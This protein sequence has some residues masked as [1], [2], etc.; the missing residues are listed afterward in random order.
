MKIKL[1]KEQRAFIEQALTSVLDTV[2]VYVADM[3]AKKYGENDWALTYKQVLNTEQQHNWEKED[4]KGTKTEN[5]IDFGHL[6][7][8]A[9]KFKDLWKADFDAEV[10]SLPTRFDQICKFRNQFYHHVDTISSDDFNS[11]WINARAIAKGMGQAALVEELHELEEKTLKATYNADLEPNLVGSVPETPAPS[12]PEANPEEKVEDDVE[13]DIQRDDYAVPVPSATYFLPILVRG[14][15]AHTVHLCKGECN[16]YIRSFIFEKGGD[17]ILLFSLIRGALQGKTTANRNLL[18][19]IVE[20]KEDNDTLVVVLEQVDELTENSITTPEGV[21]VQYLSNKK[22]QQLHALHHKNYTKVVWQLQMQ[23][24][25]YTGEINCAFA[26]R[27]KI[28]DIALDFGSEASQ[29]INQN[30][31]LKYLNRSKILESFKV[32]YYPSLK[33]DY[34]QQDADPELYRSQLF[35]KKEGSVMEIKGCPNQYKGLDVI[36]MLTAI[37]KS[38]DLKRDYLL[39]PNP[40]LA[41]LGVYSFDLVFKDAKKSNPYKRAKINSGEVMADLRQ[42]AINHILHA[43]LGNIQVPEDTDEKVYVHVKLLVPNILEQE[44][45]T[46]LIKRTYEFL[47]H[48]S[49]RNMYSIGGVEVSIISES[50]ASFLGYWKKP[51]TGIQVADANYLIIDVGKGTTDFSIIQSDKS[52]NLS[53]AFRSGFVGAGGMITY[54]FIETIVKALLG[55]DTANKKEMAKLLNIIASEQTDI[56]AKFNFLE[57]IEKIKRKYIDN[58]ESVQPLED[59]IDA[60]TIS[61]FRKRVQENISVSGMLADI[62][63]A[64]E[65]NVLPKQESIGDDFGLIN[66]SV[67][68]WVESLEKQVT[69]SGVEGLM[70]SFNDFDKLIL[71]GRGFMFDMLRIELEGKLGK[72]NSHKIVFRSKE[73]EPKKICLDGVFSDHS[74]NYDASLVGL[75]YVYQLVKTEHSVQLYIDKGMGDVP[76]K[77]DVTDKEDMLDEAFRNANTVLNWKNKVANFFKDD[78]EEEVAKKQPEP[79]PVVEELPK[80]EEELPPILKFISKGARFNIENESE[81]TKRVLISN[82]EYVCR[83]DGEPIDLMFDGQHFWRRTAMGLKLLAEPKDF[84]DNGPLVRKTLFPFVNATTNELKTT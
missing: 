26:P 16:T 68:T 12:A 6:R 20:V 60:T 66:E 36:Q 17:N 65:N 9:I 55:G 70:S 29:A 21:E 10:H 32:R 41:H 77:S 8:I 52:K 50:D 67:K 75:P 46:R 59:L 80:M 34:H 73:N 44:A 2:R 15:K 79:V 13:Y 7:T 57:L 14:E 51:V 4:R 19:Q 37:V 63:K 53:S 24:V 72:A 35:V 5:L 82:V 42:M 39:I 76:T 23:E 40:K 54:A 47:E 83:L 3:F 11:F 84:V 30:R 69:F 71:S 33:P 25:V 62:T 43:L 78:E 58:S 38:D 27:E 18:C 45:L 61:D 31:A 22:E 49:T 56:V 48:P 28:Y 64:I 81:N 1:L 74:I